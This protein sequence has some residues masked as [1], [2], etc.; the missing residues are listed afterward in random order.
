MSAST[1]PSP[2]KD[3]ARRLLKIYMH[4]RK[5]TLDQVASGLDSPVKEIAR[6]LDGGEPIRLD[7]V[8]RVLR[9]L[10]VPPGEFF[11]RLY[12]DEPL[13]EGETTFD[14]DPGGRPETKDEILHREEV[15]GLVEEARSL[16]RG[17]TRM[18]EARERADR[19]VE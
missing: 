15:E 2:S 1:D 6:R 18:S 16:I 19:E 8:E 9:V 12:S 14:A 5:A 7:W 13:A 11:A 3:R 4:S 10:D 17:A